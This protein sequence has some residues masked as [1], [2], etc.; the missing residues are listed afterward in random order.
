MKCPECGR[1]MA[2]GYVKSSAFG[3]FFNLKNGLE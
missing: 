2:D 3:D 1:E